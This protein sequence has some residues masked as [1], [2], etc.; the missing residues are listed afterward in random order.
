MLRCVVGILL[1][2]LCFKAALADEAVAP[3]DW[4]IAHAFRYILK[5]G[6][7]EDRFSDQANRAFTRA[8]TNGDGKVAPDDAALAETLS[9]ASRRA[10]KIQSTLIY[11]L[12]G[13]GV[14]TTAELRRALASRASQPLRGGGEVA[15][16]PT[17]SQRAEILRGL[18]EAAAAPDT[19][20]DGRITFD[21][22]LAVA[23]AEADR[24]RLNQSLSSAEAWSLLDANGDGAITRAE[25]DAAVRQAFAGIDRNRDGVLDEAE[26][27]AAQETQARA[28]SVVGIAEA[29]LRRAAIAK[30][31]REACHLPL[32]AP[33]A[34]LVAASAYEGRGLSTVGL[35]GDDEAVH[36]AEVVI[37]PGDRPIYLTLRSHSPTIWRVHGAVGRITELVAVAQT[38]DHTKTPRVGVIG[39]P[40]EKVM[41][42]R[43]ADC[44]PGIV[45]GTEKAA[46]DA[47]GPVAALFGRPADFVATAYDVGTWSLPSGDNDKKAEFPDQVEGPEFGKPEAMVWGEMIRFNPAGLIHIDPQQVV[48]AAK[49][50]TYVTLPQEAG[51]AKLVADGAIEIAGKMRMITIARPS[52]LRTFSPTAYRIKRKI[53]LPAALTGAHLV[54]FL[55]PKGVPWPEGNAGHSR[56]LP[57]DKLPP[58]FKP[59]SPE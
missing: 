56:I 23:A 2:I 44:L 22:M 6:L 1:A 19:N 28:A 13:D 9:T 16:P 49:P 52:M 17:P 11:D 58:D 10:G 30:K 51:L 21:E 18:V 14:V 15:V 26:S 24:V 46:Q 47:A 41:L 34:L 54:T 5:A 31:R 29:T 4:V 42:P 27:T 55:V 35:G 59:I 36:V 20:H 3:K 8:D 50:A 43:A 53:R 32:P 45:K 57:E 33:D 12:D 25:Y 48:A 39:V 40:K 7:T 38:I 37:E